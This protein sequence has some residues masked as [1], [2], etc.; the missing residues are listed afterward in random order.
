MTV[1]IGLCSL[2]HGHAFSYLKCLQQLPDVEV[3][4]AWDAVPGVRERTSNQ[5]GIPMFANLDVLLL[6]EL[7]A[8]IICSAN[9]HHRQHVEMFASQVPYILC[10]K[11]LATTEEDGLAMLEVCQATGTRLQIAFPVRFA[12]AI[13]ETKR[14]LDQGDLGP[15]YSAA[16]TN[17]GSMP[18]GWFI[19][20]ALSGG[21][22]VMDHTVHVIDLLRWF[23]GTEVSEVYAEIGHSLLHPGLGLDDVG[24]LSFQLANGVYGTL[25]TSWSRPP[26][27]RI[28][29]TV[30]LEIV[31]AEGAL[32]VDAF[33]QALTLTSEATN[34]TRMQPWGL[35]PD[36][37]L[38]KDFVD[39]VRFAKEPSISGHDG[40]QAM[41]V[42][43]AA[44]ESAKSGLPVSL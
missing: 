37:G 16:C 35:S 4:G 17:Q 23:W 31:G 43:L 20:A 34:R 18:G 39:S 42:A 21:G 5:F 8:V 44:Y 27:Y 38:I 10:E 41:R 22:A 3:V 11:P 28:W 1:R 40:L 2:A 36:M 7:D 15:I 14:I 9:A 30:A 26:P 24:L 12:P 6:S 29:G 25:D 32:S 13:M 33:G 19:D